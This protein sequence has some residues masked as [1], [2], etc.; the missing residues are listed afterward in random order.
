MTPNMGNT[1]ARKLHRLAAIVGQLQELFNQFVSHMLVSKN[2][3]NKIE[4]IVF[5]KIGNDTKIS[6]LQTTYAMTCNQADLI[7][8]FEER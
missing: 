2:I 8:N 3:P 1:L 7:F 4:Q 6:K 5:G